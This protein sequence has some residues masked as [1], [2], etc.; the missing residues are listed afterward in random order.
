MFYNCFILEYN[1]ITNDQVYIEKDT[2]YTI[3]ISSYLDLSSISQVE[4]LNQYYNNI[5]FV[6]GYGMNLLSSYINNIFYDYGTIIITT[7]PIT[8][9]NY[10]MYINKKL[11]SY[12]CLYTYII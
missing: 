10:K 8:T 1:L 4:S 5:N 11:F 12:C 6:L 2:I 3:L 9:T 7:L